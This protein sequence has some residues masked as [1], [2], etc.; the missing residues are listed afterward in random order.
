MA[1]GRIGPNRTGPDRAQA[2]AQ[3]P[4]P[5]NRDPA[6]RG[7]RAA[8]P[9]GPRPQPPAGPPPRGP[10]PELQGR[11]ETRRRS[12]RATPP[13][14]HR[15]RPPAGPPPRGPLPELQGGDETR[16]GLDRATPSDASSGPPHPAARDPAPWRPT[17]RTTRGRRDPALLGQ[18]DASSGPAPSRPT[19]RTTRG[20]EIRRGSDRAVTPAGPR[21]Q[22]LAGRPL[23][24]H[25]QDYK[26]TRDPARLGQSGASSGPALSRPI[27]RTTS[28]WGDRSRRGSDRAAPPAGPRTQPPASLPPH[29]RNPELQG[30]DETWRGVSSSP[31]PPRG[32]HSQLHARPAF[33]P[34]VAPSVLPAGNRME[35]RP[36]GDCSTQQGLT[37][38]ILLS[39]RIT[40][41]VGPAHDHNHSTNRS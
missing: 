26:G 2:A 25:T 6:P 24:A 37:G 27:T 4:T 38:Q 36:Q 7:D 21:P 17:P 14:G 41:L 13:A 22:P 20:D 30:V 16:R 32:Q 15:P 9:A 11:D 3:L 5:G 29:G 10:L 1:T 39:S 40:A 18:N 34:S 19:P 35:G 12:D 23:A 33:F 28:G 8:P 31:L